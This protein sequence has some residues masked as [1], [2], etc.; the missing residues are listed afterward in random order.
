MYDRGLQAGV[1]KQYPSQVVC[2]G[3]VK[4]LQQ[5]SRDAMGLLA[6]L[7]LVSGG[8]DQICGMASPIWW[9]WSSQ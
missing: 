7:D 3:R 4:P 6:K 8:G 9:S 2:V 5:R 1:E